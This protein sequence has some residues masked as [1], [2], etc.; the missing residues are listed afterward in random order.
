MEEDYDLVLL[1]C[2][3]KDWELE[4][5]IS[6]VRVLAQ[7]KNLRVIFNHVSP[8]DTLILPGD[9]TKFQ[10][11]RLPELALEAPASAQ[12]SF[13]EAVLCGTDAGEKLSGKKKE[14]RRMAEGRPLV[15]RLC[16][17]AVSSIRNWKQRIFR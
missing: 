7:K 17:N 8:D 11:F 14:E 15:W 12:A 16:S 1:L 9:I 2:G 6:S 5:T 10:L 13:W 4:D 3:A